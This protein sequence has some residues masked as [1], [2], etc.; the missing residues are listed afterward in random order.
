[1]EDNTA[2][3]FVEGASLKLPNDI[4][5]I[6]MRFSEIVPAGTMLT[7]TIVL[8]DEI[9]EVKTEDYGHFQIHI[10]DLI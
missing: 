1:M 7:V 10:D 9:L 6:S 3:R 2:Y 4:E 5:I 8:G